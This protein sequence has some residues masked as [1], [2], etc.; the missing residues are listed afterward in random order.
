MR[1]M[2]RHR[3][4]LMTHLTL[5]GLVLIGLSGAAAPS[6]PAIRALTADFA[7]ERTLSVLK[8]KLHSSGKLV[9]GAEGRLRWETVSPAKSV[10]VI[11]QGQAR[12]SYPDLGVT[13]RFSLAD[14]PVMRVLSEHLFSLT[15]GDLDRVS[16]SYD[17]EKQDN[18]V[19][20]L[21]PKQDSIKNIFKEIRLTP[22]Q[23]GIVSKVELI[24]QTGDMTSITFS[25]VQ[26]NPPLPRDT[27]LIGE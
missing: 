17:I 25:K 15:S 9:L 26:V 14:D 18:G 6:P 1:E 16:R 11:V 19:S 27:F 22:G 3:K 8:D 13:K 7:M 12:I 21:V 5:I 23:Q 4:S 2:Q 24:S 10:M 20:R